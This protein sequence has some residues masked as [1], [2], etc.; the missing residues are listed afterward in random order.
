MFF[1]ATGSVCGMW[2]VIIQPQDY[3]LWLG[4]L[5]NRK[6]LLNALPEVNLKLYPVSNRVNSPKNDTPECIMPVSS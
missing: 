2:A 6:Q 3:D 1:Y 5:E 4:E